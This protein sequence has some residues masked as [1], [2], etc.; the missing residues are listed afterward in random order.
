[1]KQF[2]DRLPK[3]VEYLKKYGDGELTLD[4]LQ[5]LPL[6]EFNQLVDAEYPAPGEADE[7]RGA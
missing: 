5:R 3:Y 1:M 6:D 4:D 7:A 2:G